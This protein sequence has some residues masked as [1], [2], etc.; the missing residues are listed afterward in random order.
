[1]TGLMQRLLG[2]FSSDHLIRAST[3]VTSH[4][5]AL[6]L[7]SRTKIVKEDVVFLAK[8]NESV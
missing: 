5:A 4:F 6:L 7:G 1:M 8:T 2:Y 3:I